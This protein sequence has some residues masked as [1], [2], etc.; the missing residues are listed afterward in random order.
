MNVSL[1]L[2]VVMEFVEGKFLFDWVRCAD[3]DEIRLVFEEIF[4]QCF[5]LDEAGIQKEELQHPQKHILVSEDV[6]GVNDVNKCRVV[7]LDFERCHGVV[8]PHNVTQFLECVRRMK[9]LLLERGISL[10]EKKLVK[11]A[12]NYSV[13]R[14]RFGLDEFLFLV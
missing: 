12:K 6:K 2:F 7:F 8:L 14:I 10:D 5:S 9:S 13:S 3:V 11:V 1:I 4:V